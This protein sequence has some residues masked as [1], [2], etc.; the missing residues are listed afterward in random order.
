MRGSD[1]M[2]VPFS[3]FEVMHKEIKQ[4]MIEKFSE[5]YE[6]NWFI[7]GEE[8]RAFE[9]EFAM[10]CDAK[11]CVGVGNGLDA[12]YLSLKALGIG[13]GDEVLVPS[14]TYIATALAVTYT[15]ATP[16]LVEPNVRTFN[17]EGQNLEEAITEKTKAIIPVHLYGQAAE[18]DEVLEVAEKYKLYVIEDC[19]QAHG[20]TYKGRKVGTFGNIG[21]FSFYPGKNLGALGDAGAIITN[22]FS[23]AEKV[24]MLSN[25]GAARKYEH[26]YLGTNSRLDEVQAA[27]LRI[28]LRHLD[29]YNDYRNSVAKRYLTEINN[30]KITLP[31]IGENR[32]HVWHIFA[33]MCEKRDELQEY[34]QDNGIATLCHYPIPICKQEAYQEVLCG[35]YPISRQVSSQELSIPMYYGMS[36]EEVSYVIDTLN[37]F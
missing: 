30:P 2:K 1:N 3:S 22:D 33:I 32:K 19:A 6:K 20:A 14:N 15:G 8:V 11:Y 9:E 37:Q 21:C 13:E 25:Y 27:F 5:V 7:L 4:E 10:Y 35:K 28:K 23:I 18:M 29:A 12:I 17:M 24:R 16:V 31:Y 26:K 36:G 34:L